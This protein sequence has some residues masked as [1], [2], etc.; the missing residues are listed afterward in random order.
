M[1]FKAPPLAHTGL[2]S[3]SPPHPFNICNPRGGQ[4]NFFQQPSLITGKTSSNVSE[5]CSLIRICP[6]HFLHPLSLP[7][8]LTPT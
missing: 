1:G 2:L 4:G 7:I 8:F 6:S 3:L 5:F